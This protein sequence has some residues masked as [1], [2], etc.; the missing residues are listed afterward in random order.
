[1]YALKSIL[2]QPNQAWAGTAPGYKD[3]YVIQVSAG[4]DM[5]LVAAP[6][7]AVADWLGALLKDDK[8]LRARVL[9]RLT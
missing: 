6:I 2:P 4:D 3:L 7:E 1:M 5:P 9:A 8:D